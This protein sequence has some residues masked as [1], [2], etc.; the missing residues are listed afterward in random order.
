MQRLLEVREVLAREI[1]P[2]LRG[3]DTVLAVALLARGR[4]RLALGDVVSARVRLPGLGLAGPR[5]EERREVRDVLVAER[6]GLRLHRRMASR[7]AP[8]ALERDLDVLEVLPAEL[9]HV[10]RRIRVV[11]ARHAVA[12]LAGLGEHAAA[13][14]IAL[15]RE[16]R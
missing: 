16:R 9:R 5:G 12:T 13:R 3:R 2:L 6:R 1:R 14:R 4:L 8:I 7:A 15:D 10:V 11:R